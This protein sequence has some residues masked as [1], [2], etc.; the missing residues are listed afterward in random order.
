MAMPSTAVQN[1]TPKHTPRSGT[2]GLTPGAASSPPRS[3][4]SPAHHPKIGRSPHKSRS[5]AHTPL[6]AGAAAHT[7]TPS[8]FPH[9]LDSSP[10]VDGSSLGPRGRAGT[11]GAK[12]TAGGSEAATPAALS[13][14]GLGLGVPTGSV[15]GVSAG[16]LDIG[17]RG[18]HDAEEQY[19]ARAREALA[20]LGTRW[21]RVCQ[22]NVARCVKRLGDLE[23]LWE[24]G[25]GP[26]DA[27]GAKPRTLSIAGHEIL[28]EIEWTGDMVKNV[29]LS[30]PKA[31]GDAANCTDGA[32]IL[33]KDLTVGPIPGGYV[34]LDLFAANLERLAQTDRLGREKVS[35]FEALEGIYVSL[36]KL[37]DY[38]LEQED[39]GKKAAEVAVLCG[40]SGRPSKH[41]LEA[42][43]PRIDY[44]LARRSLIRNLHDVEGTDVKK[45]QQPTRWALQIGCEAFNANEYAPLRISSA[46]IADE[47]TAK[48]P[49]EDTVNAGPSY[50]KWQEPPP[51]FTPI[52]L[53]GPDAM[54]LDI[55]QMQ[56]NVRF[57]ARLE[58]SIILPLKVVLEIYNLV[59]LTLPNE[60]MD[61]TT[62]IPLLFPNHPTDPKV[63]P[64]SKDPCLMFI[65]PVTSYS[66]SGSETHCYGLRLLNPLDLWA[67]PLT[68]IPFS[69]PR[70]LVE[71][72]PY[73]RQWAFFTSLLQRSVQA[74]EVT[75]SASSMPSPSPMTNGH[76]RQ[77]RDEKA[78][79]G[80]RRRG[81]SWSPPSDTDSEDEADNAPPEPHRAESQSKGMDGTID[82]TFSCPPLAQRIDLEFTASFASRA[83]PAQALFRIM[84]NAEIE[85]VSVEGFSLGGEG[86]GKP[87]VQAP[88]DKKP[89]RTEG[90]LAKVLQVSEDLG[91][92]A[93]WIARRQE[94]P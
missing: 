60:A 80:P 29:A 68:E 74:A 37:W 5:A 31:T 58:P 56:P 49:P 6:A 40:K 23:C 93:E 12:S 42:L 65:R 45:P 52:S 75:A 71:I 22:E 48:A 54:A 38:E 85:T 36:R 87:E 27:Q 69:H 86:S 4:P 55:T 35:C 39:E 50:I 84:P 24:D 90:A 94:A 34:A 78:R 15:S 73:L 11:L 76:S 72:L 83:Q 46:W 7:P 81:R 2:S 43:G 77:A 82:I 51:S 26:P 64:G 9:A 41:R 62:L 30:F 59:G 13:G 18:P 63:K 32:A 25:A 20:A 91:V 14:L 88:L 61:T 89:S 67:R 53:D 28:L 19:A 33:L 10:A 8:S 66:K 3:V 47:V 17:L 57:V 1:A 16:L 44:W 92:L 21:G 79:N 70:Q